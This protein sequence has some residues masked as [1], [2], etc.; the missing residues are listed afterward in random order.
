MHIKS[1]LVYVDTRTQPGS[2][3]LQVQ[4]EQ[5]ARLA[6]A[7]DASFALCD[8]VE[9]PPNGTA[10]SAAS[11]LGQLRER[12][13]REILARLASSLGR[14]IECEC[15]VLTGNILSELTRYVATRRVDLVIVPRPADENPRHAAV[16]AH[17]VRKCPANIW[18]ARLRHPVGRSR[19]AVALDRELFAAT[20]LPQTMAS[21]LIDTALRL[22]RGEPAPSFHLLHAWQVYGA[23]LLDDPSAGLDAEEAARYV[24]AQRYSHTLWLEQMLGVLREKAAAAGF[25]H[26]QASAHL[27]EGP[28]EQSVPAWLESGEIDVLVMGNTGAQSAPGVFIGNTSEAILTRSPVPVVAVKP[29]GFRSPLRT[30]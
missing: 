7:N 4:L 19:I 5:F 18:Q 16:V 14:T 10:S 21:R 11:R 28:P 15:V 17:L 9:S 13:A 30:H 26:W 3:H 24:D 23:E 8:V 6:L 29:P 22:A 20:E 27:L 1:I 12:Y 2:G 25:G